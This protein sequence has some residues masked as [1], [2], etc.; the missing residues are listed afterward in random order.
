MYIKRNGAE[1]KLTAEEIFCAH[2]EFVINWMK[3]TLEEEF[4]IPEAHSGKY[5]EL[6]YDKYSEGNGESEYQC[7][8]AAAEEYEKFHS[9]KDRKENDN[10]ED[11]EDLL[12][13]AT[14]G[15]CGQ[16]YENGWCDRYSETVNAEETGCDHV[17]GEN[18]K[19]VYALGSNMGIFDLTGLTKEDVAKKLGYN[20]KDIQI[21][22]TI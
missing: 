20:L 19:K 15:S 6:A 12:P 21:M 17:H 1:F 3:N 13:I 18:I 8:E 14:C 9:F 11:E 4:S 5:A 22:D 2:K 7:V 16:C 10:G